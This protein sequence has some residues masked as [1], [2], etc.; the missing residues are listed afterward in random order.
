MRG[1]M[2]HAEI[3]NNLLGSQYRI[4][5]AKLYDNKKLVWEISRRVIFPIALPTAYPVVVFRQV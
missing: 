1:M 4:D 5:I 3:T 2:R